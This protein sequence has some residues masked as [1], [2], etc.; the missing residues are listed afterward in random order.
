[1]N[2]YKCK[3][4]VFCGYLLICFSAGTICGVLCFRVL[5]RSSRDWITSYYTGVALSCFTDLFPLFVSRLRPF[6]ILIFLSAISFRKRFIPFFVFI[7]GCTVSYLLSSIF[8]AG[9]SVFSSACGFLISLSAFFWLCCRLFSSDDVPIVPCVFFSAVCA[10][11]SA[12]I[13]YCTL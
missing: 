7:R 5:L 6:L 1:M 10:A 2:F 4:S 11:L 9:C 13:Q 3:N 12:I 8:C